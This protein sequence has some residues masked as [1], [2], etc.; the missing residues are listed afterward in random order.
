MLKKIIVV[1]VLLCV[2]VVGAVATMKNNHL[3]RLDYAFGELNLPLVVY[4]FGAF[5]AGVLI[6]AVLASWAIFKRNRQ[7]KRLQK[8][9]A[10]A[11]TSNNS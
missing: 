6:T 7:I 4:L 5:A 11:L 8:T 9:S 1:L 10:A 3:V 2:A